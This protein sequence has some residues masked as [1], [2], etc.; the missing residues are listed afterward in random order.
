MDSC[1]GAKQLTMKMKFLMLAFLSALIIPGCYYDIE[2]ELYPPTGTCT[3]P[4]TVSLSQHVNPILQNNNCLFC[5]NTSSPSG[6]VNL[7][8]YTGIK[9]KANDGRLFGAINHLPGFSPMPQGGN[10]L[11]TCQINTIKSW[12]DAGAPNN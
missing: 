2:E 4:A 3:I 11:T 1:R 9:A 12:I 7:S 5:H 8:T 6:N 10:K